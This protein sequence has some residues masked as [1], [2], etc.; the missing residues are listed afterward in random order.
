L[1]SENPARVSGGFGEFRECIAPN[2]RHHWKGFN[3]GL[4]EMRLDASC[5]RIARARPTPSIVVN[6]VMDARPDQG[7]VSPG[8]PV[9]WIEMI[10]PD[11]KTEWQ[12]CGQRIYFLR[13]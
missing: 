8:R 9:G 3:L 2:I 11:Q 12:S 4:I 7:G 13:L 10:V 6:A 1:R 5:D